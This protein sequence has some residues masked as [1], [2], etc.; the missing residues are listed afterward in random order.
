MSDLLSQEE[1]NA[2]AANH[3]GLIMPLL[4]RLGAGSAAQISVGYIKDH[5]PGQVEEESHTDM[6]LSLLQATQS[7][8]WD[9]ATYL[10]GVIMVRIDGKKDAALINDVQRFMA[11]TAAALRG[12]DAAEL[13]PGIHPVWLAYCLQCMGR[14][15][16]KRVEQLKEVAHG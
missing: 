14:D 5:Q 16:Q 11:V 9:S 6:G 8:A 2:E 12:I 7:I 13:C 1:I 15:L 4:E 10:Y 3:L